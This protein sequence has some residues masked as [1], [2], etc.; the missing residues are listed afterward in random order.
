MAISIEE[1]LEHI[2]SD[3]GYCTHCKSWIAGGGVEPDACNYKCEVC[4]NNTVFGA[5]EC[6]IQ[7][8]ITIGDD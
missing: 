2:D 8:L 3:D 1:L 4:G 5:E 7:E 6:M